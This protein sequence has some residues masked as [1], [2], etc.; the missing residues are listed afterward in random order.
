MR[1]GER[2]VALTIDGIRRDHVARYQWAAQRLL[3]SIV[4]DLACGIGYGTKLLAD[5]AHLAVGVDKDQEA[6]GYAREHYAHPRARF[7][8]GDVADYAKNESIADTAVCFETIEHI[9]DPLPMLCGLRGSA[10]L[11]LASV[12]NEDVFPYRG[13]AFHYRHYT[14]EQFEQLLN[15][16]GW[17]VTEWWGQEGPE[18]EVERDCIGRTIIAV[19]EHAQPERV[20]TKEATT[21]GHLELAKEPEASKERVPEHVAILGLGPS[22]GQYLN[23]TKRIGARGKFCDEVWAIN[24]LGDILQCDRTF[25]MDD[26]RIQEIRAAAAPDSNIAA[27]LGWLKKHPGPIYTSRGHDDYPGLVEYPLEEVINKTGYAYFNNTAAY[28]VAYAVYLGVKKIS[29][30]GI[31]FTYPNS[32]QREKGRGCV[33]WW[34]GYAAARGIKIAIPMQSSLM[35]ALVPVRDKLYG[36]DTVDVSMSHNSNGTV[37]VSFKERAALP[38][39]EEIEDRYDH[40]PDLDEG[41]N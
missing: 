20:P 33:E 7:V 29:L 30:F 12:P 15:Q 40:S 28:A 16:A 27:M 18:S 13:Y 21:S 3:G 8:V 37:T 36:Y 31:D 9:K 38:T 35:D 22:V 11:L 23:F 2:Q 32:H 4:I 5:V 6:I 25:H 17:H 41:V 1:E 24:A 34:L 14:K 39:A 10:R 19:A 26:V